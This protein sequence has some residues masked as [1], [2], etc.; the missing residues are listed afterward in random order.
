MVRPLLWPRACSVCIR[1][2]PVRHKSLVILGCAAVV[3]ALSTVPAEA[4]R[5]HRGGTRHGH[6]TLAALVGWRV[7][8]RLLPPVLLRLWPVV[9]V[10]ISGV[11][12]SAGH[13]SRRW[14]RHAAAAGDAA[15]RVGLRRRLC[16]GRGRRLRRRV[17]AAAAR[18]RSARNRDLSSEPPHAAT[19]HLLQ[20]G[21]DR[22]RSVTRSIRCSRAT[23]P[24]PQPVPRA[25]PAYA[26]MPGQPGVPPRRASLTARAPEGPAGH[27]RAA[28]AAGRCDGARRRRAVAR[29]A[30]AGSARHSARRRDAPRAD[31]ET[32][33]SNVRR[34]RRRARGRNDQLQRQSAVA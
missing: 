6:S 12:I 30:D 5:R 34:R 24:E 22:T 15:R 7:S 8:Q 27:A 17:P 23:S 11:W 26:G 13:L 2:L 3:L 10:S 16:G 21:I 9:S 28:R 31:R 25:M 29:A 14:R 32:R 20:P 33:I 1:R 18:A 19:E 4:Q